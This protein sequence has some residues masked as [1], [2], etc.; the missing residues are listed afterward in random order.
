METRMPTSSTSNDPVVIV[1]AARTPLGGFQGDF[2]S[3][4]APQ[5]GAN[6]IRAA[7]HRAGLQPEAVDEMLMG[8]VLPAGLGQ[9]PARQ[10][11]L[12]AG[13]PHSAGCT[14]INKVCGSGMKATMLAHDL[15]LTGS[16]RVMVAGGMESMSNAPYLLPKAR[17]GQRLGH[18]LVL[19][20]MFFDGLEDHYGSASDGRLMGTFA[21]DCARHFGFSREEQD[22]YAATSTLRAQQA[23][24]DGLFRWE[25]T[26]VAVPGRNGEKFF[27]E[28]AAPAKAQLDKIPTLKPAFGKDGTVTAA[29]SSSI[30]DGAAAL[31]LMRQSTARERGLSTLAVIHAHAT[32]SQEPAWFTTAPVGAIQKLLTK[33]GWQVDDVDLWEIN[34]AFAVVV[35]AAMRELSLP[36]E[37]VNVHGGA[38]ALGHPIGATGARLVVTLLAALRQRGARRGV[39]TVCIGGG[40]AT[41]LAIEIV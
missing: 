14:T 38:C 39:A 27:D 23:Q 33:V 22:A 6:A 19:D 12:G 4:T 13:L 16:Q 5:L 30:S 24:R 29:N 10:A 32:H 1:G 8:C 15:L 31:V 21:E 3:L 40:E 28:D 34:E 11:A 35:M 26:P 7:V 18:G 17:S 41:A 20:H 9:A 37:R 2:A 25:I 36:H